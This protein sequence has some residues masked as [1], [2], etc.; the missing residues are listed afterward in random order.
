M[1]PSDSH[2]DTATL[3]QRSEQRTLQNALNTTGRI[4]VTGWDGADDTDP[5]IVLP[6]H[7]FERPRLDRLAAEAGPARVVVID[8]E[9]VPHFVDLADL[10]PA[11]WLS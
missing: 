8:A 5:A 9:R 4:D 6:A 10:D 1:K 7:Y 2:C 11:G 3:V